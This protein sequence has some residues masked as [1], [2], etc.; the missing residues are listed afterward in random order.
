[1]GVRGLGGNVRGGTRQ[2]GVGAVDVARVEPGISSG[3][4]ARTPRLLVAPETFTGDV[5]LN[6]MESSPTI[7][8]FREFLKSADGCSLLFGASTYDIYERRSAPSIL[9]RPYGPAAWIESHNSALM[10]KDAD[11]PV[12]VYHK[13]RLVVG[14]EL[15]PYPKVFVPIENAI[16]KMV[17]QSGLM[18][19]CIGQNEASVLHLSDSL[20]IGC[21]VCYESVYGE[22]CAEYVR[23]GA[24][25]LAVITNDAWWGNTPGYRQH[26]S[27]S[28]LRAIELRRDIAR[29]AITGISAVIDQRGDFVSKTPWWTRC[30]LEGRLNLNSEE[31]FF[32]RHGDFV[33]RLSTFVFLLLAALL[34]VK[35]LIKHKNQ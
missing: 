33:G 12:E 1:S 25:A 2:G 13:S 21:A 7:R 17:G 24:R 14:T 16:A 34:L 19:H 18:G 4:S 30:T 22:Y 3:T 20:A 9:A 10:M 6:Y 31:T 5:I 11:S 35:L 26:C 29:S 27:Y 23:K 15:T 28:A 32:V 8:S